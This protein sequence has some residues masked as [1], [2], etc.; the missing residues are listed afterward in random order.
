M[1]L[2]LK[3]V[4][5]VYQVELISIYPYGNSFVVFKDDVVQMIEHNVLQTSTQKKLRNQISNKQC[6]CQQT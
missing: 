3:S 4:I 2:N 6:M 1:P 5:L